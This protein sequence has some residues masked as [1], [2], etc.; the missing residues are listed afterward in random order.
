MS[1]ESSGGPYLVELFRQYCAGVLTHKQQTEQRLAKQSSQEEG[2]AAI[3]LATE[4]ESESQAK[5]LQRHLKDSLDKQAQEVM[6]RGDEREQRRY[7]EIQYVM[8]A[9]TDEVF[10]SMSWEGQDYWREHLLE[11]QLFGTHQSGTQIFVNIDELLRQRDPTR[12]DVAATYLL[13][14]SLNFRGRFVGVSGEAEIE[15]YRQQLFAFLFQR[16]PG[17]S[18][19]AQLHPQS[20]AHTLSGKPQTWMPVLRPWLLA[21]GAL[22]GLYVVVGHILW[23]HESSRIT[24]TIDDLRESQRTAKSADSPTH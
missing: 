5:T 9:F 11:E 7:R 8:V 16:N 1:T 12:G 13:A 17:L 3:E 18:D 4:E 10:L 21:I 22:I 6:R 24:R 19:E 20:Y 14:L 2:D 23:T 15:R